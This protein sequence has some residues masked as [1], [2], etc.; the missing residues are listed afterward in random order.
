MV[1]YRLCCN[2]IQL[3]IKFVDYFLGYRMPEYTFGKGSL[4]K[5]PQI[6]KEKDQSIRRILFP[7]RLIERKSLK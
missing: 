1:L 2:T 6:I 5:L 7:T 4:E 3:G